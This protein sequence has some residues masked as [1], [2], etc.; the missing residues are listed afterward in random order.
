MGNFLCDSVPDPPWPL[1]N[2]GRALWDKLAA[3]L[4]KQRI[5]AKVDVFALWHLC[6]F[7]SALVGKVKRGEKP[8]AE[9]CA[10]LRLWFDE[11]RL[12]YL[13]GVGSE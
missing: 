1:D 6:E 3:R 4:V 8:T 2:V 11:F 10:E 13:W 12:P 5:L 7:Q 9:E